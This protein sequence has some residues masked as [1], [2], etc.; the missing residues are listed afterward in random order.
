MI[1]S[2]KIDLSGK[3]GS[4]LVYLK[5]FFTCI[6]INNL[7]NR[8]NIHSVFSFLL[9]TSCFAGLFRTQFEN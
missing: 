5:E 8:R 7:K 9:E 3:F 1:S 2:S 4:Y 6:G